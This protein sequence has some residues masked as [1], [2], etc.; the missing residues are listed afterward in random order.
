MK[1]AK[2][3]G[4]FY[5]YIAI[6]KDGNWSEPKI[7]GETT[8]LVMYYDKEYLNYEIKKE[9]VWALFLSLFNDVNLLLFFQKYRLFPIWSNR[10]N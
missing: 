3:F 6:L 2:R 10:S 7:L 8:N 5:F 4:G 1:Y 9:P